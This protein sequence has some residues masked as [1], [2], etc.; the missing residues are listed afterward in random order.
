MSETSDAIK[1]IKALPKWGLVGVMMAL[2]MLVGMVC[3]QF[4]KYANNHTQHSTD[5]MLKQAEAT[6]LIRE[7]IM[8]QTR[9]LDRMI[10]AQDRQTQMLERLNETL[11]PQ[12]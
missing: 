7:S 9:M 8:S 5:A 12:F 2:I 3:F 6:S 1:S 4:S 10:S 11:K